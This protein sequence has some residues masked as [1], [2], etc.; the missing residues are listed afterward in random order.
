LFLCPS[1]CPQV[2]CITPYVAQEPDE[3]TLDES[4]V[5]NVFKKL[6]DGMYTIWSFLE[7]LVYPLIVVTLLSHLSTV[8]FI[9]NSSPNN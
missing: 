4:D 9:L 7:R 6:D 8:Q 5:V 2:Q 1:D 3:L